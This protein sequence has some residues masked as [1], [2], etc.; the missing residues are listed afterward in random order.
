MSLLSLSLYMAITQD[1]ELGDKS[2]W[3]TPPTDS[4]GFSHEVPC[5]LLTCLNLLLPKGHEINLLPRILSALFYYLTFR[6]TVTTFL[7]EMAWPNQFLIPGSGQAKILNIVLF[8]L[9]GFYMQKKFPQSRWIK[10]NRLSRLRDGFSLLGER[11]FL[12]HLQ[13]FWQHGLL[14]PETN[15]KISVHRKLWLP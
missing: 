5:I 2:E 11:L 10:S 13:K 12:G 9:Q 14:C 3:Q 15:G 7:D 4:N 6:F 8:W 1:D